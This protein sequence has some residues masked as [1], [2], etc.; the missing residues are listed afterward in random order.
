MSHNKRIDSFAERMKGYEQASSN[1]LI[2]R[3]P[4]IIRVDGKN[5]SKLTS[6]LKKPFDT[7]IT[8]CMHAAAMRLV[9][10]VQNCKVAYQQSDEISL[11]LVDFQT[12]TTQPWFD[13]NIQK[14]AAVSAALA[15]A[16]FAQEFFRVFPELAN[17]KK[18]PV[19]DG[20]CFNIPRED[21]TNYFLWRQ[22]DAVRNSV[23][24]A[25]QAVFSQ[26]D[27]NNINRNLFKNNCRM[28][29]NNK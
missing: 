15:T 20:R 12:L 14:L 7:G 3:M 27:L 23:S 6:G 19:F 24:M 1:V 26:K 17:E 22:R 10:E 18:L 5:F 25:A 8:R 4:V 21:V 9:T 13:N 2:S 29:K 11:L 16:G 28:S